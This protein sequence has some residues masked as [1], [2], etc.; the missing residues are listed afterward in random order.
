MKANLI[1]WRHAEAEDGADDMARGLT[2]KGYKQAGKIAAWLEAHLPANI[3]VIAS[4]AIR[5]RQTAAALDAAH[6]VDHRLNPDAPPANYLQV[7]H[8]PTPQSTTVLVGHQPS[9]GRLAAKL[10]S[11]IEADWSAKKGAIWWLQYRVREGQ[12]Q[13]V[14]KA[15]LT[16]DQL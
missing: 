15:M 8:W 6:S 10:L 5:A 2:Q 7:A 4:E 3:S 9:I 14:L 13:T 16:P 11:G 1:L 12:P